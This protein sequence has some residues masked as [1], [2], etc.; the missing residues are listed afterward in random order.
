MTDILFTCAGTTDP[1]R[2]GHDGAILH[3]MRHY[4]PQKVYLFLSSEMAGYE[5]KDQRFEKAFRFVAE[6]WAYPFEWHMKQTD[7]V[8]V[9][10]LDAVSEPLRAYFRQVAE[11]NTGCRILINLSSGTPQM[12]VILAQ[13]ALSLRFSVL[14]VQ[15]LN[16]EKKS[17]D[18]K[19]TNVA[20]YIVDDELELNEDDEPGAPN[21]CQ[22][23]QLLA[24]QRDRQR[25][26]IRSLLA[27]RDYGALVSM[28]LDLPPDLMQLMRH[29]AVRNDLNLEEAAKLARGLTLPFKLYPALKKTDTH[30]KLLSEYYL[31]L[32]NLQRTQRYTEFVLRMNPFLTQLIKQLIKLKLPCQWEDICEP[33]CDGRDCLSPVAMERHI[34]EI[35]WALEREIGMKLDAERDRSRDFSLYIGIPLLRVLEGLSAALLDVLDGCEKLNRMQRNSAAH[36]LHAVTE[37]QIEEDCCDKYGR[38]YSSAT[39][40][41]TFGRLLKCAYSDVCDDALFTIYDQCEAYILERL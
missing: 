9:A 2:G 31:L 29:L 21:R 27:R 13:L 8:D 14:G 18:S 16:P 41:Q 12:K 15:V 30:Y 24:M 39:L 26:Q 32:R 28:D 22:E 33:R 19:R 7:L 4:R 25:A 5:R 3:I 11:E 23:P 40:V 34:P 20:A 1:V 35:K 37:K 6:K 36:Q 17:G 38:H 10:D